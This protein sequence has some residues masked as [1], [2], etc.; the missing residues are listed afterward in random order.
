VP[1]ACLRSPLQH[2]GDGCIAGPT[3]AKVSFTN[4]GEA[5]T[6]TLDLVKIDGAWKIDDTHWPDG[7]QR[8]L[9]K[10]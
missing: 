1:S 10:Q 2:P 8:G 5:E 3:I 4:A 9:Y 7:S 6:V